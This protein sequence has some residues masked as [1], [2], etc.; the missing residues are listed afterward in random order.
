MSAKKL[1]LL[2]LPSLALLFVGT[3]TASYVLAVIAAVGALLS[4]RPL[5]EY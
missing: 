1:M 3:S 5:V 4:Y 2:V